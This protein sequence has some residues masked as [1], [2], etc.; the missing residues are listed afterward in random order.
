MDHST[1]D[2]Q[3]AEH[4]AYHFDNTSTVDDKSNNISTNTALTISNTI[5]NSVTNIDSFSFLR[6]SL[7]PPQLPQLSLQPPHQPQPSHYHHLQPPPSHQNLQ[8]MYTDYRL[9]PSLEVAIDAAVQISH[10]LTICEQRDIDK[11]LQEL[12][13]MPR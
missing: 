7:R 9:H 12:G 5:M 8:Q 2:G 3:Y 1:D 6:P 11:L 4:K 13:L 10:R